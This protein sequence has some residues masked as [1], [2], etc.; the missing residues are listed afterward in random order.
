MNQANR[1]SHPVR[2][3]LSVA[4]CL[5]MLASSSI[6]YTAGAEPDDK[7]SAATTGVK[8]SSYNTE[9]YMDYIR[10][11]EESYQDATAT[12]ELTPKGTA[13]KS[14]NAKLIADYGEG[15]GEALAI[16]EG[17][18][19]SWEITVPEKGLYAVEITYCPYEA[20]NGNVKMEM[21][22]DGQSPFREASLL[23][24]YQTWTEGEMKV[25]ANGN[26][27]K[28][29]SSQ[30]LRWQTLELTDPSNYATQAMRLALDAGKHTFAL[31]LT[32]N[33]IA[34]QS[35]KLA[36]M[37]AQ[38]DYA[39]YLAQHGD[40][41][42]TG[43]AE[44]FEAEKITAKS[45]ATIYPLS[46]TTS[47]HTVPQ[48][49]GVLK[50]N[51]IGSTK[52]QEAG[53][54]ISWKISAPQDGYY[55]L[56]FRYRQDEL[57]GMFVTRSIAI[58][59]EVPYAEAGRVQFPY[60]SGWKV[61]TPA[62]DKGEPYL[63]YLT[64]G[65][66]E[67]TMTVSLGD[68]SEL[69]GRIDKVLT[70]LNQAYR[71]IM[72]ITGPTPDPYRDYSF[73]KLLPDTLT[74]MGEQ[75]TE[76][77]EVI[78]TI[79]TVASDAADYLSLLNK[80]SFQIHRMVDKPS[81]IASTFS[82]FKSNIGS[83]GTWLLTAKQQ[84]LTLDSI[85]VVPSETEL[86]AANGAWYKGFW[87]Q[88]ESFFSSF[89]TDYSSIS[90]SAENMNYDKTIKVWAPTGRDQAQIIR[91]LC[92][93]HFSPKYQ[94]SVDVELISGGTLLPSVL[95][96]VGP[97]VSLMNGGGDPI[98]YA[99]RNAVVDLTE[100]KD[101]E[102]SPGFDTVSKWFLPASLVPYT[103]QGKTYGLPETMTFSMFFYRKD[104]FEELGLEVPKTFDELV[105]MIPTLQ[106][107]NMSIAF[108]TSYGGLVLKLLQRGIPLY[109]NEGEST[110]LD[111]DEALQAFEEMCEI[112]TTY[113]ADVSYDFVNRFRTG[114]MP[115]GIQDYTLYNQL[116]VFAPEIQGLWEFVPVP[117]VVNEDGSIS[118]I[119]VG[120]G[121]AV[122]IMANAK[123]KQSSWD[124]VQ[125]WLSADN[126]SRYATELES[127]LGAAAKHPTANLN[128]FTGLTW[129]VKD[130]DNIVSQLDGVRTTPE[131]PGGYYTSRVVD[132]AFNR[133]YNQSANP[134]ETL[135][136][137]IE[138][139]ND[140]LTR[141]RN[142]FRDKWDTN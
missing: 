81:T 88:V 41:K 69:L 113:R 124:F 77:D 46:D 25:D 20:H 39:A 61:L 52:W 129:S 62:D 71:S 82:D 36:P 72:M 120:G 84:P 122:M 118:N 135:Q 29:T 15:T 21:T 136:S 60:T 24:L 32:A 134:V 98:N 1:T 47:A 33:S 68:L 103:Y 90:R 26:D 121:G 28:P 70:N 101:T 16:P 75:A 65:D 128:A 13:S 56:A 59:G 27:V 89:V 100:F 9:L 40:G 50:L 133:V 111:S 107:Y 127:V 74:L 48:Q 38:I 140:E 119:T 3:V 44:R 4:C 126:Q 67:L 34:I 6:V 114:E 51:V 35:I 108:P 12:V 55:Q 76:M 80:L 112:F 45:D 125:W 92:D 8:T 54:Y 73:E 83:L 66:H 137:Y 131:V 78:K 17:G 117:G 64:A 138:D 96:G 132:F 7:T 99:I 91:Q 97:D 14:D 110:N 102:K 31:A 109:N 42:T 23:S 22:I 43:E 11:M 37:K 5:A 18:S 53:Q 142:E 63:F 93:E 123:D 95:A 49:A 30:K 115:C 79:N 85:Y 116:T 86:P 141:K 58:D 94:V 2:R 105:L 139:L 19:A 87:Y 130:R 10:R 57:S 106:R 104:I